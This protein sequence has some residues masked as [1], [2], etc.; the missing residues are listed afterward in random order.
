ILALNR[1]PGTKT[2]AADI[3]AIIARLLSLLNKSPVHQA[4]VQTMMTGLNEL[5]ERRGIETRPAASPSEAA[6]RSARRRQDV[7]ARYEV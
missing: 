2:S 3:E 1:L 5:S 6:A 7:Q 4:Y